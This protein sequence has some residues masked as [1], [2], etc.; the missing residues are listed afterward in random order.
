MKRIKIAILPGDG[1]GQ[2]VLHAALPVFDNLAINAKLYLANI[3]WKFWQQDGNPIP[4]E[5]WATI[6][7]CDTALLGAITSKP[8]DQANRELPISLQNKK[9]EYTSPL[10]QLRQ[11]LNLYANIRPCFNIKSNSKNFNFVILRENT[12][13]LYAGFDYSPIPDSVYQLVKQSEKYSHTAIDDLSCTLRVLSKNRLHNIFNYAFNYA[14]QN[15]FEKVTF[16]DKPNVLRKSS[17]FASKIFYDVANNF[18]NITAEIH[19]VD[20]VALN[21]IRKPESFGIIVTENMF[22]D[23]LS[24]V[25]AGIMGGLGFAPSAN[26]GQDF[27][28]FEPVHGSGPNIKPGCANP[29]AMFLTIALLLENFDYHEQAQKIKSAVHKTTN[30]SKYITY[31]LGGNA[32]TQEMATAILDN[33]NTK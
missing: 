1:I 8:L 10:I 28:Y 5:T 26:I 4:K 2:E 17:N 18:T 25:A 24:D 31:D 16:A 30:K 19:N 32:T 21:I 12:E 20:A 33:I 6:Q 22:G 14:Q 11:K 7:Q 29:S 23:I 27:S 9:I 15:N 3:G 13:G